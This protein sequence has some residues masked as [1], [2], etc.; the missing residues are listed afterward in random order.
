MKNAKASATMVSHGVVEN[1]L[2]KYLPA[3]PSATA[4]VAVATPTLP[5]NDKAKT[6]LLFINSLSR[7]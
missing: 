1:I 2:S 3:R 5:K 6:R 4:G 7:T